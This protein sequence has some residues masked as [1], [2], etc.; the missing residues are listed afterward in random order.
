[1]MKF[2]T[3]AA[4]AVA[5]SAPGFANTTVGTIGQRGVSIQVVERANGSCGIN[6]RNNSGRWMHV[7]R[8]TVNGDSPSR[9]HVNKARDIETRRYNGPVRAAPSGTSLGQG[10]TASACEGRPWVSMTARICNPYVDP[11]TGEAGN[12]RCSPVRIRGRAR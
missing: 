12:G 1:M 6:I 7:E 3:A 11:N 5:V 4:L 8:L 2:L 10:I 9:F